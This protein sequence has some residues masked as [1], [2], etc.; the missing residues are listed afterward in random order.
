MLSLII[1][2]L[3]ICLPDLH[4]QLDVAT[5][6]PTATYKAGEQILFNVSSPSG[7]SATYEIRST[8]RSAVLASGTVNLIPG[9][10]VS[11]PYVSNDPNFVVCFVTQ[12]GQVTQAGASI[13]PYEIQ[14]QEPEPADFDAFWN[15]MKAR[16]AAVP[17]DPRVN[18]LSETNTTKTYEVSLGNID[19]RRVYGYVSV[20][21]NT[22][23][24]YSAA[25]EVPSF[26]EAANFPG[27]P[28]FTAEAGNIIAMSIS[29]HNAPPSGVDPSAY[30][31][32][33][34]SNREE[35]YYRYA[36]LAGIRAI[37]YIF[38]MPEFDG[39]SLAVMGVSQGGGL[40][41]ML[42]GLD[43]RVK[44]LVQAQAALCEHA[45]YKYDKSSGFPFYYEIAQANP[46]PAYP[47]AVLDASKYYDAVYFSKR[48]N[49]P[50]LHVLGYEDDVCAPATNAA[51]INQIKG[52]KIILHA[53]DLGHVH[54]G[55]Y[56]NG[57]FDFFRRYLPNTADL[58]IG[59]TL[60]N[61]GYGI[62]A[63]PESVNP[64]GNSVQLNGLAENNG[65]PL[66]NVEWQ[67][68]S[69]PGTV[70]FTNPNTPTSSA[71]FS[72]PGTYVL[73]LYAEDEYRLNSEA[74]FYTMFDDITVIAGNGGT[75]DITPP[76][77]TLSTANTTVNGPFSVQVNFSEAV[78]DFTIDDLNLSNATA[79]NFSGSGSAFTF[80]ATPI[81]FGNV[82]INIA[83]GKASDLAGNANTV[84]NILIVKYED[85]IQP[86][87]DD[88]D[89]EISMD[90]PT[91][92]FTKFE[93]SIF[94]IT[95][96]NK[97]AATAENIEV[98]IPL[99]A[100]TAFGNYTSTA[101]SYAGWTGVWVLPSLAPGAEVSLELAIYV[102]D[103]AG[104]LTL[105][106]QVIKASPED[107]DSTPDNNNS[108]D[109]IE[110]DEAALTKTLA[111]TSGGGGSGGGP[112]DNT[113]PTLSL[114]TN[115]TDVTGAFTVNASLS[116]TVNDF[117]L[118][119]F[120]VTNATLSG[121]SGSAQSY[122]VLVT[123]VSPGVITVGIAANRMTDAAGNNNT[124]SN[125]LTINY[126][127]PGGGGGSTGSY[128]DAKGIAPWQQW[129]TRV[130]LAGIDKW[131]DKDQ[132]ADLTDDHTAFM[133]TGATNF[134]VLTP[135]YSWLN[136]DLYWRVW[137]DLNQDGDFTDAGE[138]VYETVGTGL[139]EGDFTLP[140]TA[141][142]GRTRIRVAMS[143]SGYPSPCGDIQE[144]EVEDYS[145]VI[146]IGGGNP[147]Q[148]NDYCDPVVNNN[149]AYIS[150]VL[151]GDLDNRTG[152]NFYGDFTNLSTPVRAGSIVEAQFES[153]GV[154]FQTKYWRV[155]IDLNQNGT[156]EKGTETLFSNFGKEVVYGSIFVPGTAKPGL[157]RMRI[158][159]KLG[160]YAANPCDPVSNGEVEDYLVD[161]QTG[162]I[163]R[164]GQGTNN[165]PF[166]NSAKLNIFPNPTS[167]HLFLDL[168]EFEGSTAEVQIVHSSGKVLTNYL[169]ET[170]S[171]QP[172]QLGLAP[173]PS[174]IYFVYVVVPGKRP[175]IKT[176]T[177]NRL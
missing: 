47:Q 105:F 77:V 34:P 25:L 174:G 60:T 13:S 126:I 91:D 106:A 16:L 56:W 41:L 15:G 111:G 71:T 66:T 6:R 149:A 31:P 68:I 2:I 8:R 137:I 103:N 125:T 76:S 65:T 85:D 139:Q 64:S 88:I 172:V 24:P 141:T 148:N 62:D 89:L 93:N 110:D 58:P 95:L 177:K 166:V 82:N 19:N 63:G 61:K 37:D 14:P 99:P 23:G 9:G 175:M 156:F 150:R 10:Q 1:G 145:A 18:L 17:M 155:W 138:M 133:N 11:I 80:S 33:N 119:D 107:V 123:P 128:C 108:T 146:S 142:A 116:E 78:N 67:K 154:P 35:N 21:K 176:F 115:T 134:I 29:I 4:A 163:I 109:P 51:A 144:G 129:I 114:S 120:T 84:S 39:E 171:A 151:F 48:F 75:V 57:R 49:G 90:A 43:N 165:T 131:S 73:R 69:G 117:G 130:Q 100:G 161:M 124:A 87:G 83:P 45:G 170:I 167:D 32:D 54:P 81:D 127:L 159:M 158:I 152:E 5:D 147:T 26:G 7:G 168:S 40:A 102:L 132:Y 38:S 122:S 3:C 22:N 59:I 44:F 97:G 173:L 112:V 162:A 30:Q 94:T 118:D 52:P 53:R 50:S 160:S 169:V 143:K 42:A 86:G 46:D 72:E 101:G 70:S 96:S 27:S 20:P 12:N 121:F 104:P 157:T 136:F 113:A 36:V 135:G 153:S 79:S 92:E 55:E 28:H 164:S 74:K 140:A 98:A